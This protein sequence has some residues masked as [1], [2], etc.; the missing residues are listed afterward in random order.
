MI[1]SFAAKL[2]ENIKYQ[3]SESA[4]DKTTKKTFFKFK[5]LL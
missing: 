1:H 5:L 4:V 2:I 3:L